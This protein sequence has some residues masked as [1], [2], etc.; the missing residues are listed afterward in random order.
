MIHVVLSDYKSLFVPNWILIWTL[1]FC[2]PLH[3]LT[4]ATSCRTAAENWGGGN[5]HVVL[6]SYAALGMLVLGHLADHV[7]EDASV[8][9]I[10]Q[11]HVGVE[12][13]PDLECFPCVEL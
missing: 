12:S 10:R 11:L 9:E 3:E 6:S 5:P 13:H 7:V 1:F 4:T 8:V 2:Q